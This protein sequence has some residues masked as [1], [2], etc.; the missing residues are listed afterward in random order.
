MTRNDRAFLA[1]RVGRMEQMAAIRRLVE[2]DGRGRGMRVLAFESGSGLAFSVY[3]DRGMDIGPARYKGIPLAWL[4]CQPPAAPHAY[5]PEGCEWLRTWG[6]GLLTGCGLLNVGGPCAPEG[7]RHGL[8]GRL[9]HLA[10]EEVNTSAAWTADGTYTLSASGRM[11]H[12]R[13]FGENLT[14][15]R[16]ISTAFDTPSVTVRDTIE[17]QGFAPSPVMLLYH[18]NLGWPL[19][20]AGATLVMPDHPVIPQNEHA[21]AGL[22]EWQRFAAPAPGFR[23][24][25]YYHTLPADEQGFASA[26]LVNPQLRLSLR[27]TYRVAELP[28]LIQWKMCGRG[29]YVLGLEPANCYPEGREAAAR[30]GNLRT[31]EPGERLETLLRLSVE[32][33]A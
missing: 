23:E 28:F 33:F 19:A 20:D 32:P 27:V 22:A 2:D 30:R 4:A 12:A 29:E 31:L 17:N 15:T 3:P 14:L 24:Q 25:V 7:E 16:A 9:S 21:A 11:R 5:D 8:H 1:A 18:I 13:V 10:A 26:A 6:G